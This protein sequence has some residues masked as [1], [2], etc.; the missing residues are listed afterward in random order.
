M[1]ETL[2][3]RPRICQQVRSGTTRGYAT[4]VM[5]R[6]V[7]AAAIFSAWLERQ[8]VAATEIDEPLVAR[9]ITTL[10][11]CRPRKGPD[12][13]PEPSTDIGDGRDRYSGPRAAGSGV[14]L[15]RCS[16]S[17]VSMF[18]SIRSRRSLICH[19][20]P[21]NPPLWSLKTPHLDS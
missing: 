4:S 5:R 10:T 12:S 8:R 16:L 21:N 14:A 7:R 9:F 15:P 19:R 6:H 3:V 2:S 20:S 18:V 1:P 13:L 17:S 11:P